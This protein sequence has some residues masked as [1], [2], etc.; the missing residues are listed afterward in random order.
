VRLV[1]LLCLALVVA[2]S[3]AAA[4]SLY[5][6]NLRVAVAKEYAPT[7]VTVASTCQRTYD[8]KD[9][10]A[11]VSVKKPGGRHSKSA[12]R[13]INTAGWFAMWRDG[14]P[15]AGV[16]GDQHARVRQLVARLEKTCG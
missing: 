10:Y 5:P 3:A 1:V 14:R 2:A 13:F 9:V 11:L 16:P 12:F 8:G 15:T 7:K 6:L 4:S